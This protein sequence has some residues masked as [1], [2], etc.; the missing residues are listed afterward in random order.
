MSAASSTLSLSV[1]DFVGQRRARLS[2]VPRLSTIGELIT[3]L[4]PKLEL[5][6]VNVEGRPLHYQARLERE[7]RHVHVSE[8]VGEA[9]QD[10]DEITLTPNIDAGC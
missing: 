3:S 9:L 10:E 2:A 5:P 6:E 8:L 7:Q 4:V 1:S